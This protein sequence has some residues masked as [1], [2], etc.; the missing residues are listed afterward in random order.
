V[1]YA[2]VA[3]MPEFEHGIARLLRTMHRYRI[4]VMCSE[5]DPEGC[6][7]R[8]LIAR[9]LRDR[10]VEVQHIRAD[11]SLQ[12]DAEPPAGQHSDAAQLSLFAAEEV[13]SGEARSEEVTW[14]SARSVLPARARQSSSDS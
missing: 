1:L 10:G 3:R 14:R 4:A 7:R 5:E 13:R 2:L 9:V 12:P 8:L 11:G 6:H